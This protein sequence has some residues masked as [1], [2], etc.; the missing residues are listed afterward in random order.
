MRW[1][2]MG[3]LGLA[4][5]SDVVVEG[6]GGT[7]TG[8]ARNEDAATEADGSPHEAEPPPPGSRLSMEVQVEGEA[9][10]PDVD[11]S[12]ALEGSGFAGLF[13]GEGEVDDDGIYVAALAEGTF[14][15]PSGA[16]AIPELEVQT[17]T[18]VVLHAELENTQE[19]CE[20]HCDAKGR[21]TAEAEC[22]GDADEAACRSAAESEASA[23]CTTTC[24]GTTT[25]A[26][27]AEAA[28]G[29]DAL[30]ALNASGLTGS[31]VGEL[32]VDLT[33]DTLEEAP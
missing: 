14:T 26:I 17:F 8:N 1:I 30:A 22:A 21:A 9:T 7:A 24:T 3:L 23:S 4:A 32:N 29:V 13:E 28:L 33:F 6:D 12:C 5:C 27:V 10:I 11:A 2:S 19:N 16:C 20:T 18:S 31:S 15:T 25:R